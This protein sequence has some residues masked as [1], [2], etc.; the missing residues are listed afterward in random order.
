M[1]KNSG[2]IDSESR[3]NEKNHDLISRRDPLS[4]NNNANAINSRIFPGEIQ[5]EEIQ[6]SEKCNKINKIEWDKYKK[7]YEQ[8]TKK[9]EKTIHL[10]QGKN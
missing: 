8:T 7:K 3:N 2:A 6:E 4:A 9:S 5:L 1:N 10:T